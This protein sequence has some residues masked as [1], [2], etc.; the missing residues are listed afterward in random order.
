MFFFL[1]PFMSFAR[2]GKHF[3]KMIKWI[4]EKVEL[5]VE[6]FVREWNEC[7][8]RFQFSHSALFDCK[9]EKKKNIAL[10]L[11]A[12]SCSMK[13]PKAFKLMLHKFDSIS[14]EE[15]ETILSTSARGYLSI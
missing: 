10:C 8:L 2:L 4:F 14:F 9:P 6:L 3:G 1:D 5:I 7:Q 11:T 15:F 13:L 12:S